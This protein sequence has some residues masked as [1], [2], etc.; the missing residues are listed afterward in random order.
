MSVIF[1]LWNLPQKAAHIIVSINGI[2]DSPLPASRRNE[3]D[4]P[5]E[6]LVKNNMILCETILEI[7]TVSIC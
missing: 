3:K 4:E 6:L 7:P 1:L 5:S 2:P